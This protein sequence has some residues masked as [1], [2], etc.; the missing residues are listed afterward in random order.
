MN[1]EQ[2]ETLVKEAFDKDPIL[3]H[4]VESRGHWEKIALIIFGAGKQ[5]GRREVV[6]W[7]ER[8]RKQKIPK[9]QLQEWGL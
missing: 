6:E 1:L 8:T 2:I 7:I 3:Q 9:Y 4:Q 5:E